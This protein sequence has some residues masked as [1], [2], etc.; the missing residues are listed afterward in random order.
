MCKIPYRINAEEIYFCYIGTCETINNREQSECQYGLYYPIQSYIMFPLSS[1]FIFTL[2]K[3]ALFTLPENSV[4]TVQLK[5]PPASITSVGPRCLSYY[6]HMSTENNNS[7]TVRKVHS[8]GVNDTIDT[9]TRIPSNRWTQ[10]NV[11]FDAVS[12]HY[13]VRST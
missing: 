11:S 13:D 6:Y 1:L 4:K 2:G 12:P 3:Y 10:R 9:V 7:L 5:I 8:N